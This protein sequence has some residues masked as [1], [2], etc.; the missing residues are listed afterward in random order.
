MSMLLKLHTD[1]N[2]KTIAH[3]VKELY[4]VTPI[5][6][7]VVRIPKK[8]FLVR[9]KWGSQRRRQKSLCLFKERETIEFV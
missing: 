9:G 5:K 7:A 3:A 1:A 6:V 4:N 2:K 8:K